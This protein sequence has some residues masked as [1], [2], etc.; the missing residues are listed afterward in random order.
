MFLDIIRLLSQNEWRVKFDTKLISSNAINESDK[1]VYINPLLADRV[2]ALISGCLRIL[3]R[4][5]TSR[6]IESATTHVFL[7]LTREHEELL[8]Y[9]VKALRIG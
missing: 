7:R 3:R 2:V 1:V 6:Q 9:Y 8:L 4:S 5:W